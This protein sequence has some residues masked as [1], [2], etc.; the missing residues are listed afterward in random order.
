M[1][2]TS[3]FS[4][5]SKLIKITEDVY[6]Y[7]KCIFCPIDYENEAMVKSRSIIMK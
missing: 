2:K 6:I 1:Q 5:D 7:L 3:K 4:N